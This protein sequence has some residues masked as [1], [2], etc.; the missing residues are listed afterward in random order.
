MNKLQQIILTWCYQVLTT[1]FKVLKDRNLR[2]RFFFWKT[3]KDLASAWKQVKE[4][5]AKPGTCATFYNKLSL[6]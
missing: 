6:F 5:Q 1:A 3:E 2:R 4:D